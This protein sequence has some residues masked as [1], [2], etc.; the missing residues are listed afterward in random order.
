M[1]DIIMIEFEKMRD[2]NSTKKGMVAGKGLCFLVITMILLVI[3]QI[4]TQNLVVQT[5][6]TVFGFVTAFL[7]FYCQQQRGIWKKKQNLMEYTDDMECMEK[8]LYYLDID[9]YNKLGLVIDEV[10]ARITDDEQERKKKERISFVSIIALAGTI[11]CACLYWGYDG[12]SY[13]TIVSLA[14]FFLMILALLLVCVYVSEGILSAN[15]RYKRLYE[16]LLNVM[17]TK[18]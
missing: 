11:T 16:L 14:S 6:L 18:F 13:M 7:L 9:T 2:H 8:V 12:S 4:Y 15:Q 3:N 17:I 1:G 10:R 5:G